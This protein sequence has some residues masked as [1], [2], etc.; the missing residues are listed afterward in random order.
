[1]QALKEPGLLWSMSWG[2]R[3]NPVTAGGLGLALA[4]ATATS[5]QWFSAC[6]LLCCAAAGLLLASLCLSCW[7]TDEL[8]RENIRRMIMLIA[9]I[10][11]SDV[12]LLTAMASFSGDSNRRTMLSVVGHMLRSL[13][14]SAASTSLSCISLDAIA[15]VGLQRR[16]R[17]ESRGGAEPVAVGPRVWS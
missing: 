11:A 6:S 3:L 8:S 17:H 9:E 4:I 1:M 14:K 15:G 5:G 7:S 12:F 2:G 13:L 10:I 16:L